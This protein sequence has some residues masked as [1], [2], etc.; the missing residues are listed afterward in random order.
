MSR[1]RQGGSFVLGAIVGLLV[2]LA[3]ALGVALY[4]A[5]VPV[6]FVNKV[7][8]RTAEQDAAEAEKN[9]NW[10]PNSSLY[11]KV[12]R[13]GAAASGV[14]SGDPPAPAVSGTT[15]K[16]AADPA[17]ILNGKPADPAVSTKPGTDAL[18]YFVQAGAFGRVEDAENQR[19]KLAMSGYQAKVTEREQSGRTVYRVRL[20]PFD[21]REEA[22]QVKEKLESTGVESALVQVQK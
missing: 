14:V 3:I 11:S 12:P 21:K 15:P 4:I 17:A 16:P 8:Q 5:K 22:S 6:P 7:P 2:G 10:D 19:A 9:K 18:S 20:G 13:P 1:S